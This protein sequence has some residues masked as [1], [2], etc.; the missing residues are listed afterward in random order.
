ME[1]E[2]S[3]YQLRLAR[4][5]LHQKAL[6][7]H[8]DVI[9]RWLDKG[10]DPDVRATN[11]QTLLH[12]AVHGGQFEIVRLLVAH[13]AD[14]NACSN[15]TPYHTYP[16]Q[17]AAYEGRL[18]ILDELVTRGADPT[19]QTE[20]GCTLLHLAL[21][22]AHLA[23]MQYLLDR[24]ADM[25]IA[26]GSGVT[27][28]SS[29]TMHDFREATELLLRAGANPNVEYGTGYTP[30][31]QCRD[32]EIVRLLIAYGAD[33]NH[34]GRNGRTPLFYAGSVDAI[35]EMLAHGARLDVIDLEGNTLLH[36]AVVETVEIR[37]NKKT[38]ESVYGATPEGWKIAKLFVERGLDINVRNQE[39]RT[40]LA[41]AIAEENTDMASFLRAHGGVANAQ[42]DHA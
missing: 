37:Y 12:A 38:R 23:V 10:G 11:G 27:P 3:P 32:R 28:L 34:V 13:G 31:A 30:L 5:S 40:P 29:A 21:L 7:G 24:G 18:E 6:K 4:T 35:E 26:A 15:E 41:I 39:G 2:I 33:V 19:I 20:N 42:E 1:E 16:S 25:E 8:I 14:V 9:V 36:V 22:N 17:T